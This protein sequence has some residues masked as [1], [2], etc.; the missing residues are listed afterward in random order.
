MFGKSKIVVKHGYLS[1]KKNPY[2]SR[3]KEATLTIYPNG[4]HVIEYL[5]E[6]FEALPNILGRYKVIDERDNGWNEFLSI[7]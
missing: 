5:G 7:E 2:C 3:L 4:L 6:F 1:P